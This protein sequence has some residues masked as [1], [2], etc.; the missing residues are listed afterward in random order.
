GI[1]D[2]AACLL[3]HEGDALLLDCSTLEHR[4]V[5]VVQKASFF[6]ID[7]GRPRRLEESGYALRREE[8]QRALAQAG[9]GDPRSLQ[10]QILDD[11]HLD[12]VSRRRLRHVVSE[13]QRVI[14][15]ATALEAGDLQA[16]G[17]LISASHRSLRDDYAVSTV[18]LDAVV[19][20]AERAGAR[21]AR[22]VGGGFG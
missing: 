12:A 9:V 17:E 20:L 14:E 13:N 6:V 21:G 16:A 7:P 11:L 18:E 5:P 3:A 15:F 2:Q 10:L 22:L 19:D 1:L 8:L 4:H